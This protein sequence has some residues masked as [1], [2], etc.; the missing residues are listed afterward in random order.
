VIFD[1]ASPEIA[2]VLR[3]SLAKVVDSVDEPEA[4]PLA[5]TLNVSMPFMVTVLADV[6]DAPVRAIVAESLEPTRVVASTLNVVS[7]LVLVTCTLGINA[8]ELT[9][10]S[11]SEPLL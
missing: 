1:E 10:M 4:A 6:S 7:L 8:A 2:T 3:V 5:A 9:V 11:D